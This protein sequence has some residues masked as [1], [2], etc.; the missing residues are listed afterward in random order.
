MYLRQ[1]QSASE[2]ICLIMNYRENELKKNSKLPVAQIYGVHR[3]QLFVLI[4]P[5]VWDSSKPYWSVS[6]INKRQNRKW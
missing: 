6:V 5:K 3:K 4:F 1:C 2:S